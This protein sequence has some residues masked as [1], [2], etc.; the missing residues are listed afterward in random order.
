MCR[1]VCGDHRQKADLW[2]FCGG[3]RGPPRE[4]FASLPLLES[5]TVK[6]AHS[7]ERQDLDQERGCA[8]AGLWRARRPDRARS[9]A[10]LA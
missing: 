6:G 8:G 5:L 2:G 10:G 3:Q 7:G 9:L 4:S 1:F